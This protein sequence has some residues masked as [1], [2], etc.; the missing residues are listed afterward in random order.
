MNWIIG[1]LLSL[2][3]LGALAFVIGGRLADA[4]SHFIMREAWRWPYHSY[5]AL[6]DIARN[7]GR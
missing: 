5:R 7:L 4:P 1:E 3:L 6:K 2:Y